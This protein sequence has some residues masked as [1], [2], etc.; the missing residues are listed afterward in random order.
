[1]PQARKRFGQ[2]FLK[3]DYIISQIIACFAPRP[4]DH[5]VEIGPGLGALTIPLLKKIKHLDA[6][7]L[8]RD[9]IPILLEKSKAV[10]ELNIHQA[11]VLNFD[12][13]TLI[14]KH[15]KLRVIGNL[16]YNIST[17]LI[18]HLLDQINII[19]DMIFM[20]QQEVVDRMAAA[21]N[22]KTYGR[23]SVMVQYHCEVE[24]LFTIPPEAFD[25]APK[26]Y[27]KL[28]R[29]VPYEQKPFV[30]VD[31]NLF[32]EIVREAF[33]HRRKTIRNSLKHLVSDEIFAELNISPLS[34]AENLSV[35]DYVHLANA[36]SL[37]TRTHQS[38]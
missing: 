9:I 25:P 10:G 18:F 34:R 14:K 16:P 2:N 23:L 20:L 22:S 29:L 12:F 24:G 37:F 7:E 3:D 38:A 21:P 13:H 5:C 15:E 8:D 28:V 19:Q 26:V 33:N 31:K 11:D 4:D 36:L 17:P 35:C 32:A 27:S 6:I 30:A 1:M